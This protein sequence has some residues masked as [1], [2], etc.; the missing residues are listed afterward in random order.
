MPK[1]Y[2]RGVASQFVIDS[3]LTKSMYAR[4]LLLLGVRSWGFVLFAAVAVFLVW[5]SVRTGQYS[6]VI[7]YASL[8]V[9]VYCGAVLVSVLTRKNRRAYMPVRYTFDA[10]GVVKTTTT[11]RQPLTWGAFLR[12][13]KIGGY[14]L[15]YMSKRSFFVIPK[16]RIQ[17]SR[18]EE[19]E[20]LLSQKI[21]GRRFGLFR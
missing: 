21:A 16:A 5:T 2:D 17:E 8:M 19:F 9:A 13:R 20:V 4:I 18:V 3:A 12:W 15:I 11:T 6:L 10:S 7:I 1:Q 14:Y